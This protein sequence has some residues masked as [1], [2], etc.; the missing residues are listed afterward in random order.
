MEFKLI[1]FYRGLVLFV[2]GDDGFVIKEF[3]YDERIIDRR[4]EYDV[5]LYFLYII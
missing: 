4:R 1:E 5:F 3:V 2:K